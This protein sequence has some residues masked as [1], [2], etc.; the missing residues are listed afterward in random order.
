LGKKVPPPN[1]DSL[2]RLGNKMTTEPEGPF[3]G[4]AC[5]HGFQEDPDRWK[6]GNMEYG[7]N[8]FWEVFGLFEFKSYSAESQI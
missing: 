5:P 4:P 7:Q 3:G 6:D 2:S 8:V 1:V